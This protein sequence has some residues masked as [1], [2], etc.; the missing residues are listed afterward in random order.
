MI[1]T[2]K[3]AANMIKNTPIIFAIALITS[4]NYASSW[5]VDLLSLIWNS[6]IVYT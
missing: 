4:T 1:A 2:I 6:I 3:R 5:S